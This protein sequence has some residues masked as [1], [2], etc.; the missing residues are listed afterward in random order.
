MYKKLREL[1]LEA[2]LQLPKLGLVLYTFGNASCSDPEHKVF[3]IKPSGVDYERLRPS[4]IVIVGFDGKVVEGALRPSS[5]TATHAALYSAFPGIGGIVH[6]HS[7]YAAAWA[8]AR[9]SIPVYG[10]THADHLPCSVPCTE[11]MEDE[12]IRGD[13]EVETGNQII[14]LFR[15]GKLKPEEVEMVLV[16]G[17]GPFTWGRTAAKAVY[18]ARVLEEL[19]HT[20]LLTERIAPSPLPLKQPIIDKHYKRKHGQNAYYGQQ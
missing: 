6:T 13:Y 4:D 16:G 2:N 20:A 19:A 7:T 17:H 11:W 1:C 8:Q 18:N 5:D 10:T 3:A 12:R 15:K 9:R 14:E